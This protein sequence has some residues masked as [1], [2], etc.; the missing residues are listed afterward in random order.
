MI[1]ITPRLQLFH[2]LIGSIALMITIISLRKISQQPAE[3]MLL[4]RI[5]LARW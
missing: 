4:S 5:K 2:L 1:T 3:N